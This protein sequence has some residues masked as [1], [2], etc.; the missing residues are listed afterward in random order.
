MKPL[1]DLT[2]E[3]H[4]HNLISHN[5]VYGDLRSPLNNTLLSLSLTVLVSLSMYPSCNWYR[6]F[7]NDTKF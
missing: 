7:M 4:F 2:Y 5:I 1:A 6:W 3:N